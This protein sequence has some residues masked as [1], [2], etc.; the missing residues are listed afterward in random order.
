MMRSGCAVVAI[1]F[2]VIAS[3]AHGS[4]VAAAENPSPS[5]SPK[6]VITS[7]KPDDKAGKKECSR[8]LVPATTDLGNSAM[9]WPRSTARSIFTMKAALNPKNT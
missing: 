4:R 3:V 1:S 8:L 2:L 6:D 5:E 9:T 7:L